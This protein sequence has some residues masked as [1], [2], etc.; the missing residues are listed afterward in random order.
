MQKIN[1]KNIFIIIILIKLKLL[2]KLILNFARSKF[3][4]P[5]YI[6]AYYLNKVGFP[7]SQLN[8]LNLILLIESKIY[9]CIK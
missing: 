1:L 6:C 9:F 4:Y 3:F 5:S 2:L 8:N 7:Y